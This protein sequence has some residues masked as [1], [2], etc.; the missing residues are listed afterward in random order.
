LNIHNNDDFDDDVHP[1][2]KELREYLDEYAIHLI[3]SEKLKPAT[4]RKHENL[5]GAMISY[6]FD[7]HQVNGFEDL[8]LSIIGSKNASFL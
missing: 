4:V 1:F 3:E 2:E 6:V 8:S 5:L 7:Y